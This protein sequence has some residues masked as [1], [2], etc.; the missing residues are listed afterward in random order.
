MVL[1][2]SAVIVAGVLGWGCLRIASALEAARGEM[3]RT[4]T[5]QVMSV[6]L[7]ASSAAA[8]DPRAV[9]A[10]EPLARAARLLFPSEFAE[11]DRVCG[12]SFPLGRDRIQA[13]HAQWTADWLSWEATH[14]SEYKLK[15]AVVE[16][17]LLQAEGSALARARLDAIEREKLQR[18]QRRYQEYVTVA[19]ALQA[20]TN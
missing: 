15:A 5:L 14:D 3:A 17:E 8:G 1:L 6:F 2:A 12:G 19:K 20:L 7:Q 11:L 13:A 10:W 16:A 18:Y 9:L 4:R